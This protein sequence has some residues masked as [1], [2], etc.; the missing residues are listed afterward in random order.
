MRGLTVALY[1]RLT[2]SPVV[3][4]DEFH[5]VEYDPVV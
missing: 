5:I 4:G 1:L 3:A 2:P